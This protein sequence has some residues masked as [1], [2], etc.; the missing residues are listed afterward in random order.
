MEKVLFPTVSLAVAYNF[1]T[2]LLVCVYVSRLG[3]RKLCVTKL[4]LSQSK[5]SFTNVELHLLFEAGF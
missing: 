1:K 3:L 2:T 5:L 4:L